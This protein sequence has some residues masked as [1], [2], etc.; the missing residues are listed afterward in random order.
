[1]CCGSLVLFRPASSELVPPIA[2]EPR[3]TLCTGENG[4][5]GRAALRFNRK[6]SMSLSCGQLLLVYPKCEIGPVCQGSNQ[7]VGQPHSIIRGSF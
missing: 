6:L 4:F 5:P 7:V 1:M 3:D 2:M